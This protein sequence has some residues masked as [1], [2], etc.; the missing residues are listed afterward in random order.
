MTRAAK[1]Y[2]EGSPGV[3]PPPV[4]RIVLYIDDLDR[5]PE[6]KVLDVLRAVHLLLAFPLF[7]VVVAVDPRWVA[8]CLRNALGASLAAPGISASEL[9]T[10]GGASTAADY[11]EKIFQIPLWL[12]PI[13]AAQRPALVR[14]LLVGRAPP[15]KPAEAAGDVLAVAARTEVV[16]EGPA[17]DQALGA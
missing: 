14:A 6:D 11:L 7:V 2:Y 1:A 4:S 16:L 9:E 15:A 17:A 12:R 3:P 10:L 8:R 13:P 5:C